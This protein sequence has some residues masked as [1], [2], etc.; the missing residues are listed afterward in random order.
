M[1]FKLRQIAKLIHAGGVIAYPTEAVYGLGCDPLNAEAVSRLLA[2]KQRPMHKGLI[3]IAS[4][5]EQLSRFVEWDDAWLGEVQASWPGPNTWLLPAREGLP[6]WINGGKS[7]VACRVTAHPLAAALCAATDS[8]LISTSANQ[9]GQQPAKS[10]LQA[11][12]RCYGVDHIVHGALGK[13]DKP[14]SIRD[15]LTGTKIR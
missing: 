6:V 13:L 15:A 12:L 3:L 2:I 14:T 10:A 7:T 5:M 4:R 11:Q 1:N 9:A 8:A